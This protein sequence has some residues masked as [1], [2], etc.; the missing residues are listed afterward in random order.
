MLVKALEH[1]RQRIKCSLNDHFVFRVPVP[2]V[3]FYRKHIP[4][5]IISEALQHV[6]QDFPIFAGIII[7]H[8]HQLYIDCNNQGVHV[9]VT[10]FNQ[11]IQKI[12]TPT[13]IQSSFLTKYVDMINPYK[14]L[15]QA[16]P[17]L[18]IK[19]NY[20]NDGTIIGYC[21]HHSLGDMA[22]FMAFL[23]ALSS[24]AKNKGYQ[25]GMVT[26]DREH[27]FKQWIKTNFK[28]Q[29]MNAPNR[30]CVLR[31]VDKL[32]LV[33]SI[34]SQK[35]S[36]YLYFTDED[37]EN[38]RNKLS[39]QCGIK[40]SRND[41]ICA[42][43]LTRISLCRNDRS[44]FH[45]ASIVLNCRP[46]LGMLPHVLGNFL[47]TV[48]VKY[49]TNFSMEM[50]ASNIHL[51]VN[52]Y[53]KDSFCYQATEKFIEEQG[54]LKH[55]N[56]IIPEE[57]LPQYKTVV[58]SN[59]CNFGIYSIDFGIANPYLC[60]PIGESPLPWMTCIVEGFEGKGLLVSAVLPKRVAQQLI[61]SVSGD[62]ILD[63]R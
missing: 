60:L 8:E 7:K 39:E 23:G 2:V 32:R 4:V 19:L 27:Y 50:I 55:L 47:A 44:I 31:T 29:D 34:C 6:L 22:T 38:L 46:R 41:A 1:H 52:N 21:W 30:L 36:I 16:K 42:Y 51:A 11:P 20:F 3:F 57:F 53:L 43:L 61:R 28:T 48:S 24:H 33:K 17:L 35:Q 9:N 37:I 63:Q 62:F 26:N 56:H 25:A 10:H 13:D 12:K 59:W 49:Q 14:A 18:T 54:G 58:F 45:Y 5:E 15:K 40:L